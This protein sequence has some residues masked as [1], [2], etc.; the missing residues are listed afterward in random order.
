MAL[1][2]EFVR[3]HFQFNIEYSVLVHF[4]AHTYWSLLLSFVY[5]YYI[6]FE[7]APR[8]T[9]LIILILV[10]YTPSFVQLVSFSFSEDDPELVRQAVH[11][12][13][14]SYDLENKTI[15]GILNIAKG[16]SSLFLI[17]HCSQDD[18]Y[19]E[20]ERSVSMVQGN[21]ARQQGCQPELDS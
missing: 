20:Y 19:A 13:F 10:V 7:P 17:L 5:R 3:N 11:E 1:H 6:L 2:H 8:R 15:T 14:P 12:K 16:F 21:G 18:R 4:Y 9:Y